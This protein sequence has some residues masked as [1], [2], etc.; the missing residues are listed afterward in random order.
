MVGTGDTATSAAA[1]GLPF[2]A[3]T[4]DAE[5]GQTGRDP[6]SA[7][8]VAAP[9]VEACAGKRG[10]AIGRVMLRKET[11]IAKGGLFGK[12]GNRLGW[13]RVRR[14]ELDEQGSEYWR[15]VNGGRTLEAI[16]RKMQKRF[17]WTPE[18]SRKAVVTYTRD[19]MLRGL[20][21]LRIPE[22]GL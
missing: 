5:T 15:L 3:K 21:Q 14:I 8:P 2:N 16:A 7:I 6:L 17:G 13:K 10:S 20:I 22:I 11:G 19:L 4:D 1:E 9:G 18:Q 12:I